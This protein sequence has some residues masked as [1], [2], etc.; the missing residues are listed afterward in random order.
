MAFIMTVS[1]R[2]FTIFSLTLLEMP[3]CPLMFY[4]IAWNDKEPDFRIGASLYKNSYTWKRYLR[5]KAGMCDLLCIAYS[6]LH[7]VCTVQNKCNICGQGWQ[8]EACQGPC[9]VFYARSC[10]WQW[11]RYGR[12]IYN[13]FILFCIS[14]LLISTFFISILGLLP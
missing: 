2:S 11:Y 8:G 14:C 4:N 9:G 7:A 5:L 1:V 3:S 10:S 13:L 12:W 6:L